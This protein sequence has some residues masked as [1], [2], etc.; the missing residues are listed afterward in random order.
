MANIEA[1]Y[2]PADD[3]IRLRADARFDADTYAKVKAAGFGWAP[4]QDL[5]YAIWSPCREDL[6]IDLA[7]DIEEEQ[8]TREERA[9]ARAERFAGYR[10]R[11]AQDAERARKAVSAIADNIPLGQ[12]I[13]VGHHSERH[14]RRDAER[15]ENGMRKAVKAWETSEYWRHRASASLGHAEY[16]ERPDVRAR[17]IKTLEADKRKQER[18]KAEAQALVKFWSGE[19]FATNRATGE[20]ARVEITEERRDRI[21][22]LLGQMRSSG[23]NFRGVDGTL[24]YS[25][26]DVLRPDG[27][28]YKNCPAKTVAEVQEAAL[29]LQAEEIARCERWIS[30][31]ENR[32]T[33]ERAMLADGGGLAA[34]RFNLEV[35]GQVERGGSWFVITKINRTGGAVRSVS[36]AGH[37]CPT[38]QVEQIKDYRPPAEGMAEKVKAAAKLP[39]MCNYPG[40]GFKHLTSAEWDQHKRISDVRHS[41]VHKATDKHDAHRTR[42]THGPQ[43][44]TVPVYVTDAKRV[45]PPA[46]T[47]ATPAPD[48]PA[49]PPKQPG[50]PAQFV[51]ATPDPQAE[52]FAALKQ[53][54][55]AGVKVVSAPQL[56][57]TP[58]ELADRMVEEAGI[59]P[60]LTVLEPSAGT[61]NIIWAIAKAVSVEE[62][63]VH[64]V[65]I[66]TQLAGRLQ[67]AFQ[68]INVHAA[69]FLDYQAGDIVADR[70]LMNPPFERGSDI[71]HIKHARSLLAPGGRLV[72]IC[73]NGPRQK[74]ELEPLAT[75]WEELP[76]GTFA[77]EGTNVRTVLLTIEA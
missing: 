1:T 52:A 22:N 40:E 12:P 2:D 67:A 53:T 36:V 29:R 28:R 15:I 14:A 63:I 16:M 56:F 38:V 43:W 30:H 46:P 51:R 74:A 31:I 3:K 25:A 11:R 37:W 45:D 66:N 54:L 35:G 24:W 69:D 7:G 32:L 70:I 75:I 20:R 4:K 55:K 59:K 76:E 68:N 33:Y 42:A 58:P 34:D 71:A 6:A 61:G 23:V 50:V 5:F 65:E 41:M 48:L 17:R 60:G 18:A 77:S 62:V 73:A 39:P 72:A 47:A 10:A 44:S 9:E 26:W 19:T 49:L 13:L 21:C 27:E 64:A 57:P 8:T